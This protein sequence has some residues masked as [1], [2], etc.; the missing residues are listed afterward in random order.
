MK[1][2]RFLILAFLYFWQFSIAQVNTFVIP[3]SSLFYN[4]NN[5]SLT[6]YECRVVE[7]QQTLTTNEGVK[8]NTAKQKYTITTKYVIKNENNTLDIYMY[9]A[10]ITSFPNRKFSGLKIREKKYWQFNLETTFKLNEQQLKY[11]IAAEIKGKEANEYDYAITK[12][13]QYQLIYK[14]HKNF[15]QL[16]YDEKLNLK[17]FILR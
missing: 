13:T 7:A 9:T 17:E 12:H 5:D 14:R 15:K 2:L 11:F 6:V 8:L 1:I 10:G 16:V 3:K 4:L